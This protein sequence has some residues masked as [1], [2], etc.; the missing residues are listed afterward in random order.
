MD[1]NA[2]V[3]VIV[4]GANARPPENTHLPNGKLNHPG[5]GTRELAAQINAWFADYLAF[6][7][8]LPVGIVATSND[9]DT[10]KSTRR[11]LSFGTDTGHELILSP[12]ETSFLQLSAMVA[13]G[14]DDGVKVH[15]CEEVFAKAMDSSSMA[16][17]LAT[18]AL[19]R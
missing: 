6:P 10:F 3:N 11:A 13:V 5:P 8:V 12:V 2:I 17:F 15:S 1:I 19:F 9:D 14:D 18:F 16:S 7:R 4:K